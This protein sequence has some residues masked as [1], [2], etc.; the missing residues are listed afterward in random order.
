LPVFRSIPPERAELIPVSGH[1][2]LRLNLYRLRP[3]AS[4]APVVLFGHACGF[5]AGS[6][7]PLFDRLGEA[8][9]VLAYDAR[10][11]GGSETPP[12]DG[13][14]YSAES[15]AL[16]L[17]A[18][19]KAAAMIA[20]GR[21]LYFV[22]HSLNAAAMLRLGGC[23]P[24]LLRSI[25]FRALLLFE[26]PVFP[27]ADR[28][29]HAECKEKDTKLIARTRVRRDRFG[30]PEDLVQLL[31]GRGLFRH[32]APEFLRAHA[33]ATLRPADDG[34]GVTLACPP[35][36]ESATFAAFGEDSSF[37]Q[38][39]AFPAKLPVHLIGGDPDSG[40][41]RNWTTIMAPVLAERLSAAP[42]AAASKRFTQL[43]GRGHLMVQEDPATAL[44]LIR[45]L[46]QTPDL[47]TQ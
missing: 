23:H 36:V 14:T 16:D 18:L 40:A 22:G 6:Y 5:A 33:L 41:D 38:L 3:P 17:T 20:A 28:P 21:P 31:T 30:S 4:K 44:R 7:L 10:G 13:D 34:D 9:D 43:P 27:S 29:E 26:P 46:V 15:Y 32:L 2:G 12:P 25:G 47:P 35:A 1:R 39:G 19:G 37:R 11:H 8:A 24:D 45:E 42:G